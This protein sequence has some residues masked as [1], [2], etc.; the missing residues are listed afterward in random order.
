MEPTQIKLLPLC[1]LA[2]AIAMIALL[3]PV[4]PSPV[5]VMTPFHRSFQG[6]YDGEPIR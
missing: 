1:C 6:F 4:E 3:I 2:A 5:G